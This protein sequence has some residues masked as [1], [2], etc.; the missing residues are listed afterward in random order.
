[1]EG[2]VVFLGKTKEI[3]Q[4]KK[5]GPKKKKKTQKNRPSFWGGLGAQK[6]NEPKERTMPE[7]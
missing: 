3:D 2:M 6:F 5:K 1:M 7:Y 4:K